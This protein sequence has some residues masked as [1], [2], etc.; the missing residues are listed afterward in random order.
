[1]VSGVVVYIWK[2]SFSNTKSIRSGCWSEIVA[3]VV[4]VYVK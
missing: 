2:Q 3:V 1:M 4:V